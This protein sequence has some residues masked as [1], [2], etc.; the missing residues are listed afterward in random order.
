MPKKYFIAIVPPEKI[1]KQIELV[2]Q[3]LFA[4][5][6][7][8]SAL[9]SPAHITLHRPF[10]WKESKEPFLIDKL[11]KFSFDKSF[12]I[13]LKNYNC[14]EPR[15]IY[16]DVTKNETLNHLHHQLRNYAGSQLKL[17]NEI[18]DF[19]G[20]HPHVTVAFRDLKKQMFFKLWDELKIK[21]FSESF[22]FT[23]FCL[24]RL[25][26]KWQIIKKFNND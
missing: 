10:E 7:L 20:F 2:K 4:K 1:L 25:E 22:D 9:R 3:E 21:D 15:V 19:R 5:Y 26:S 18:E 8:K 17:L 13:Q 16:I 6:G 24:L 23:G 14:F 12:T 11:E